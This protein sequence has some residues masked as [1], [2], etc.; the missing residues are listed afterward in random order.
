[1]FEILQAVLKQDAQAWEAALMGLESLPSAQRLEMSK[2]ASI[3]N[4]L[5]DTRS[6]EAVALARGN[7]IWSRRDTEF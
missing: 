1:M 5:S 2:L 4:A 7:S 3:H 6:R